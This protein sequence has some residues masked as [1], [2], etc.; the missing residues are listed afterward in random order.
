MHVHVTCA[1]GEAKFW[2]E[3]VVA[4]ASFT[5]LSRRQLVDLQKIVVNH[6][7]EIKEA[8]RKHFRR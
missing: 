8:W 5:G 7:K 3:P 6:E 4:L 2:I 1:D